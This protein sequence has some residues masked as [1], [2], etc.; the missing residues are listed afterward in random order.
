MTSVELITPPPVPV[1]DKVG[2]VIIPESVGV[3]IAVSE[4]VMTAVSDG[5]MTAVSDG[6]I[7]AVSDGVMTAVSDGV[8]MAVSLEIVSVGGTSLDVVGSKMLVK[9]S[10]SP[11]EPVV[12]V[13]VGGS[14]VIGVVVTPVPD[15]IGII[16]VILPMSDE[17]KFD[18]VGGSV[19]SG[20]ES[21]V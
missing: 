14:V 21:V 13:G 6:V 15:G 3:T 11:V 18:D 4:G 20:G 16:S 8:I 10:P 7:T 19:D 17:R 2:E 12:G 9:M 1:A 5:V